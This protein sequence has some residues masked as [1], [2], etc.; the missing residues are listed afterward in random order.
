MIAWLRQKNIAPKKQ[1][2]ILQCLRQAIERLLDPEEF[3][4]KQQADNARNNKRRRENG[5]AKET[6]DRNHKRRRESGQQK[7]YNNRNN[8]AVS[9][10]THKANVKAIFP[11]QDHH[12]PTWD[13]DT[14]E[15][16]SNRNC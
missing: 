12:E 6:N 3:K 7:A 4:K 1:K 16:K 15:K 2:S 11:N 10:A 9:K 5:K 14:L 13:K 8:V